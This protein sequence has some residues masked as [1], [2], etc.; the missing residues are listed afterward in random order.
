LL[1]VALA[2]AAQAISLWLLPRLGALA[3]PARLGS[4]RRLQWL[5]TIGIDVLAF[6]LLHVLEPSSSSSSSS[7]SS[8]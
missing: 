3:E 7:P 4:Q 1:L 2:Y 5:S 6:S 8:R